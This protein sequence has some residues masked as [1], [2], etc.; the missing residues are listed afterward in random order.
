MLCIGDGYIFVL[1]VPEGATYFAAYLA[2]LVEVLVAR[3]LVPV[4]FHFRIGVHFGPVF[5]FWDPGRGK[6]GD[7]NYIGNGINGGRRVLEAVGKDQDDVVFVSGQVYEWLSAQ[8]IDESQCERI[9]KCLRNRGRKEDKHG[10]LWRVYEV[11]HTGM[12]DKDVKAAVA[13]LTNALPLYGL[14]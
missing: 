9:V 14:S 3:R 11:D 12:A 2:R 4:E 7:W 13:A 5:S 6:E 10:N 1:K 8:G